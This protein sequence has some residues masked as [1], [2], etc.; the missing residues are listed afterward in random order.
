MFRGLC[1]ISDYRTAIFA[2]YF[3]FCAISL[4]FRKLQHVPGFCGPSQVLHAN[5]LARI[6]LAIYVTGVPRVD[7]LL[8]PESYAPFHCLNGD[9]GIAADPSVGGGERGETMF[10]IVQIIKGY[11]PPYDP[12]EDV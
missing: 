5:E 10:H 12:M 7:D 9:Q 2:L 4:L 6:T 11:K 3:S 8:Q 1:Q